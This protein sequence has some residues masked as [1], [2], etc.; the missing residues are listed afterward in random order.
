VNAPGKLP[1]PQRIIDAARELFYAQGYEVT[2]D[3]IAQQASVAKP[4]IYVH[5]G[6]KDA[7]VQAVLE[8][9]SAEFFRQ[10]QLEVTRRSGDP[11]A[12]MLA[13]IDLLVEGLP[14][15]A[16]HGCLCLNAAAT[17]PDPGHP[18]HQVL[19]D[20]DQ[21]LLNTWTGLAAQAGA[22]Q[23]DALARQLMLLFDGI[24]ARGLTDNSGAAAADARAAARALLGHK[25]HAGG[26]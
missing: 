4:T 1:I 24:K 3:A 15:P 9:A 25:G 2:I 18:A 23:P 21:R 6:S 20:L 19:R 17:F 26:R 13:P 16:Y 7:L 5:F 8:S 12:R 10:L 11:A 14:D 22:R